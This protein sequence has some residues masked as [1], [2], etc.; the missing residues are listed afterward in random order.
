MELNKPTISCIIPSA[1]RDTLA[2]CL[3]TISQQALIPGDEILVVG[4]GPQKEVE[5]QVEAIGEPF[6]YVEGEHTNDWGH[7]QINQ[8]LQLAKAD[9][10]MYT[11]DDDG[12]LPRAIEVVRNRLTQNSSSPHLFR[13]YTNDH[14]LVWR[15]DDDGNISEVLIGG[16]NLVAPRSVG[17]MGVGSWTSRYR[18]DFDWVRGVLDAY[19]RREWRW[20]PE[21]LTRQRPDRTLAWWSVRTPE[22]FEELRRIRNECRES[23]TRHTE[24]I[25]LAGQAEFARW[26]AEPDSGYWPF[27]FSV[28]EDQPFGY[29][30]FMLLRRVDSRMW[31]TYGIDEAHRGKGL[32]KLIYQYALDA[33]QENAYA[34]VRETNKASLHV[35]D[36]MGW[37]KTGT[38]D[39]IVQLEHRYPAE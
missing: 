6:R 18:G 24:E 39:G 30:G 31:V 23:M 22:Q 27:L 14:H 1:G 36:D 7:T 28:R 21:I 16:H 12:F 37:I 15:K 20:C 25:S 33:C 3:Q 38:K 13:F 17:Y 5:A 34:E 8:G 26:V 32:A 19:P 11:D 9:W 10:V 29:C 35:H 4:D 2:Y